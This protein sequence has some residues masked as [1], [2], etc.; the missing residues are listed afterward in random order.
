V[1][2]GRS[3]AALP[4]FSI[5]VDKAN[6]EPKLGGTPVASTFVGRAYSFVPTALDADGGTLR[7]SIQNKPAWAIFNTA[8]GALTGTPPSPGSFENIAISAS[9]GKTATTLPAFGIEVLT[10]ITGTVKLTWEA[11]TEDVDGNPLF[12][13]AGYRVV[14]G[15]DP[16]QLDNMLDLPSPDLTSVEVEDLASGTHYFAVKAYTTTGMESELSPVS[17]KTIM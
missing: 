14:Y 1:S 4:A 17:W 3:S 9:D 15:S 7:F 13:L 10:V 11:P 16:G 2:D 8:N 12:N 5:A 6:S